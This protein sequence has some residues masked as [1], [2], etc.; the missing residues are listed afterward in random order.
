MRDMSG[1]WDSVYA[2]AFVAEMAQRETKRDDCIVRDDEWFDIAA[3]AAFVADEAVKA[4]HRVRHGE[5]AQRDPRECG[6]C[7]YAP[8][9]CDQQ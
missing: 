5:P 1:V 7:G 6:T 4:L 9:A 2:A 8:C 3:C